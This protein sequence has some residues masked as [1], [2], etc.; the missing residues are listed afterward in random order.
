LKGAR[1]ERTR[2]DPHS[3]V[4]RSSSGTYTYIPPSLMLTITVYQ[5]AFPDITHTERLGRSS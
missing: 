3:V 4:T 2:P 1:E 5:N